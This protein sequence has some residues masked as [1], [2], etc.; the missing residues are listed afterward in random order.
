[1][2][3]TGPVTHSWAQIYLD[4]CLLPADAEFA[5]NV[6]AP[7]CARVVATA[8]RAGLDPHAAVALSSAVQQATLRDEDTPVNAPGCL[9]RTPIDEGGEFQVF[10]GIKRAQSDAAVAA[11]ERLALHDPESVATCL[12]AGM[13]FEETGAHLSAGGE[14]GPVHVLAALA[15]DRPVLPGGA[16]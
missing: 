13:S 3:H 7:A 4:E 9:H 16:Q 5:T 1:M 12:R 10:C 14:M 15:H 11:T 8:R 6:A 2:L